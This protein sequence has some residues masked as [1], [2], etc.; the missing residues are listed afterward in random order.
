MRPK[1]LRDTHMGHE[2]CSK[3]TRTYRMITPSSS[4]GTS[5][6]L[7]RPKQKLLSKARSEVFLDLSRHW[8]T[9]TPPADKKLS[10]DSRGFRRTGSA[11]TMLTFTH[12]AKCCRQ[13]QEHHTP[14]QGRILHGIRWVY[15]FFPLCG[16]AV[17]RVRPPLRPVA[18]KIPRPHPGLDCPHS[19]AALVSL[20]SSRYT[21]LRK[22]AH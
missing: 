5:S 2:H 7:F 17:S 6:T 22:A 3:A 21:G 12:V 11:S 18:T 14:V 13:N 16:L 1:S 8:S 9:P 20:A 19:S 15:Q 10:A 4:Y